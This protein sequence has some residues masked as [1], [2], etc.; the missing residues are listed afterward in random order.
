MR[1][2]VPQPGRAVIEAVFWDIDGT[3]IDSEDLHYEVIADWCRQQGYSLNKKDNEILLGKS[4]R[5]KWQH[6]SAVHGFSADL[7]QFCRE[8][9][10]MYCRAL[11]PGMERA[12]TVAIF[13][14]LAKCAVPLA[15]VSNGD[16]QVVEANLA[17]LGLSDTVQFNISGEDVLEGKPSP[18]PYLL[19]AKRFGLDPAKCLA[20]EDSSVG[21]QS[22][23][24]AGMTVVAWPV[25]GTPR[26]DGYQAA[27]FLLDSEVGFPWELFGSSAAG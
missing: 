8:C 13:R 6:L 18:E 2:R 10:D 15:C 14:Q 19:A 3:L 23:V 1:S 24:A 27:Q 17:F 12:E 22:A 20:V 4:M 16:L 26:Q 11:Q 5:E 7:E 21:V 9:A 25:A